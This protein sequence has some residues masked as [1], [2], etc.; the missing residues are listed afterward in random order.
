MTANTKRGNSGIRR[1]ARGNRSAVPALPFV[2][3]NAAVTAY[4]AYDALGRVTNIVYRRSAGSVIRQFAFWRG[5][6]GSVTQKWQRL[7]SSPAS[8][9]PAP[10]TP[11]AA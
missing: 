5:A 7:G 2:V 11:S 10:V 4:Y 1:D 3:T 9:T 6:D 8:A